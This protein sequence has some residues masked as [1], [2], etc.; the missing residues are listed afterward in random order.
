MNK[1]L[2]ENRKLIEQKVE[3]TKALMNQRD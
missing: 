2:I 1:G 3:E